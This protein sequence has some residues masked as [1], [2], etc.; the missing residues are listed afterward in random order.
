M[1][2]GGVA[3]ADE[4]APPEASTWVPRVEVGDAPCA[5]VTPVLR[6]LLRRH[7]AVSWWLDVAKPRG[8]AKRGPEVRAF[9]LDPNNY[10]L[11]PSS[12]NRSA[13]AQ[14]GRRYLDR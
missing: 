7:D 13:G 5:G 8:Y 6:P 11:Q 9:M 10:I 3:M 4:D 12:M 1:T 14:L 2:D